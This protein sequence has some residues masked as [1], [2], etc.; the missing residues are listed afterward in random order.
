M[1]SLLFEVKATDPRVYALVAAALGGLCAVACGIP[2]LR[3]SG[4]QAVQVLRDE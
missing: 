2:A 3:A 1:E 4:T